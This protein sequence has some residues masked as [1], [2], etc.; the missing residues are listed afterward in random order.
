M[1]AWTS[2]VL[3]SW[4]ICLTQLMTTP[5]L[6][7]R[8]NWD[9]NGF[10]SEDNALSYGKA[11]CEPSIIHHKYSTKQHVKAYC[12][13]LCYMFD[14]MVPKNNQVARCQKPHCCKLESQKSS[15]FI[16]SIWWTWTC[17]FS[18]WLET[19]TFPDSPFTTPNRKLPWR[20]CRRQSCT[21]HWEIQSTDFQAAWFSRSVSAAEHREEK[22]INT[23]DVKRPIA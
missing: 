20:K 9:Q 13:L 22:H 12:K 7:A 4:K 3:Q 19:I 18:V 10:C 2:T 21:P 14:F 23:L 16:G 5:M 17:L 8:I 11:W 6:T 15:W 1:Y